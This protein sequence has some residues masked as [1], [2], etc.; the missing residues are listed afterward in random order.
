MN[1]RRI[2]QEG[3]IK[4][5]GGPKALP[6]VDRP[7]IIPISQKKQKFMKIPNI[8]DLVKDNK[9]VRFIKYR[10]GELYYITD[11]GF[12]FVVPIEDTGDGQFLAEDRAI[13]FMRYIRKQIQKLEEE[14]NRN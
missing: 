14:L 6:I 3:N 8:K 13:L 5:G 1:S 11:C 4:Y 7:E 10:K 9:T 12:E 2:L